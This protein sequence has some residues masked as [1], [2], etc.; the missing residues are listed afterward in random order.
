MSVY[1]VAWKEE[2]APCVLSTVLAFDSPCRSIKEEKE[3][4]TW[5]V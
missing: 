2:G 3:W 1:D 4:I 5:N